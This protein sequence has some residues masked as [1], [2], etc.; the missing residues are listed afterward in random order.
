MKANQKTKL[1]K[2]DKAYIE[3][4]GGLVALLITIIIGL[5]IYFEVSTGVTSFDEDTLETFTGYTRYASAA[6]TQTGSNFTGISITLRNS[7]INAANTNVT[8]WNESTAQQ[9]SYP[10]F[11]VNHRTVS[12][13]GGAASNFTQVNVTYDTNI[14]VQ[15]ADTSAQA[16]TVFGLMPIIALVVVAAILLG[17]VLAF[18]GGKRGGV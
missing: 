11:S 6:G 7:P 13:A 17:V 5:M 2:N 15:E 12:F 3:V 9:H 8:C 18:G 14:A 1:K 4:I 16:G 10:T